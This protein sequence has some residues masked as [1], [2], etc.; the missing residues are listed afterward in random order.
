MK[1]HNFPSFLGRP[2]F[3]RGVGG[4]GMIASSY[5]ILFLYNLVIFLGEGVRDHL[6]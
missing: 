6:P 3:S 5:G 2:V 4:R 1:K